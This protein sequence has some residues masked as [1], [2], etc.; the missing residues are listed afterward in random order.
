MQQEERER[1]RERE[2]KTSDADEY[3]RDPLLG[4]VRVSTGGEFKPDPV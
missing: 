1:E 2:R 3:A 4:Q